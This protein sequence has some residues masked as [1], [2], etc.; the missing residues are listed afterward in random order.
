MIT[1]LSFQIRIDAEGDKD[2]SAPESLVKM[3]ELSE[4]LPA[5]QWEVYPILAL[6]ICIFLLFLLHKVLPTQ[7]E[8]P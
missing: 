4:P 3:P 7:G 6:K 1:I 5:E 8:L 2:G